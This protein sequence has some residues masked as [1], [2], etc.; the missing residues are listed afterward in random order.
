MY[1]C[2][3][4]EIGKNIVAWIRDDIQMERCGYLRGQGL[5]DPKEGEGMYLAK[6]KSGLKIVKYSVCH[7]AAIV[8]IIS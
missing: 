1:N 6:F 4:E 2:W 8:T 7:S 3:R 5:I